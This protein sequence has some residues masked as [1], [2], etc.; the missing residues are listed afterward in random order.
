M[1]MGLTRYRSNSQNPRPLQNRQRFTAVAYL[2]IKKGLICQYLKGFVSQKSIPIGDQVHGPSWPLL[3]TK[4][5][6]LD[7]YAKALFGI[8]G[9][10]AKPSGRLG[11]P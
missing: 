4:A 1:L 9:L 8:K 7:S 3:I 11:W 6:P 10:H 2:Q 5:L